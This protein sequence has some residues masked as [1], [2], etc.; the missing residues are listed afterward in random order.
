MQTYRVG[1]IGLGRMG[2]TIDD[3]GH[4]PLPYSVASAARA[5]DRL[6]LVAGCD[7][8]ADRREAF[9]QRWG[10]DRLYEDFREMVSAEKPDL[11]AICTTAT[12]L[13]KPGNRAPDSDFRGDAHA[14][15]TV[16]CS[17]LGVPMLYVE[18]AVA[19]SMRRADEVRDAVERNGTLFNSGVLRRFDNRYDVVRDAVLNGDIG[20]PR[21]VV[22]Y[23]AS[24]LLHGHIH[25][26]DTVSWLL[27]DPAITHV[28]GELDPR[29][30]T[31]ENSFIP[32]DPSATYQLRF[33]GG[34]EA[35]SVPAA[36]WEFEVIGSLGSV[37]SLDNGAGAS[38]RKTA[39][40][41]GRRPS[42]EN[43]PLLEIAPRSTV[44]SCLEDLVEAKES[45]RQTR[46]HIQVTHHITEACLAVAE[47]HRLG[48]SWVEL[49][50]EDRG[51]YVFHV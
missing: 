2:S 3:E 33:E 40:S 24:S 28:R 6:D 31:I 4:S 36:G 16:A 49:P 30:Y 45:A 29:D 20:E 50:I 5:S 12:G 47:S 37:R 7:L 43:A 41:E 17:D 25:S 32:Y 23:A 44:V 9:R 10:V 27:G 48:G 19:C 13:Q 8:N 14:D 26:I 38:L 46:G 15:L 34:V 42:W 39:S 51:L 1:I 11:V 21:A 35:W 18:K 22:H